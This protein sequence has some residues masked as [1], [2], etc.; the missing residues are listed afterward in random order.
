MAQQVK[1]GDWP[2]ARHAHAH[3]SPRETSCRAGGRSAATSTRK[4]KAGARQERARDVGAFAG[5]T[6]GVTTA[7]HG[8]W[9]FFHVANELR[10]SPELV[11]GLCDRGEMSTPASPILAMSDVLR[12]SD[13]RMTAAVRAVQENGSRFLLARYGRPV[14]ALVSVA[15]L[16]RLAE[17]DE[18]ARYDIDAV[19]ALHSARTSAQPTEG[20]QS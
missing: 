16:Q 5:V 3:I 14:A 13:G 6:A 9:T 17:L 11:H 20:E 18:R 12:R 15:D 8:S 1:R 2:L 10:N 4:T 19:R 7:F